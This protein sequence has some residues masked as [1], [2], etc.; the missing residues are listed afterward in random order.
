MTEPSARQ[1]NGFSYQV[2]GSLPANYAAYV[3]RQADR[4]LYELLKQG[5]YC[6]VF[7]SRQMGK[8]SLR[9][10]AMQK[11]QG[12]GV[13][14]ATIDPQIRGTTLREDQWYAGTIKRLIDD[15]HLQERI[16]FSSWWKDLDAQSISAVERFY[17]FIDRVLLTEIPK[18]L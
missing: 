13:A 11:L 2:G 18:K 6:F 15:L 1:S 8:S 7:N 12:D 17:Y 3:E 14:C 9:V 5:E 10:R 4:E 16:N